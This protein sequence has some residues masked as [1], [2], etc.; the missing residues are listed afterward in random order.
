[1]GRVV[2]AT[3]SKAR[4]GLLKAAGVA[5]ETKPA[6]LEERA[7][8]RPLIDARTPPIGVA[9]GLAEAKALAVA[10]EARDAVVI[11]A[12]Q[13]L[14]C[15]GDIWHKP[16]S[17][18]EARRQLAALSGRTHCLHSAIA[19]AR[20]GKV[21]WRHVETARL[22]LRKLT[23]E[24]IDRYLVEVGERALASVGAYQLEG[25]GIRLF[26]KIE[27]DYFTILGLPLLPLLA[28]LRAEGEIE[29]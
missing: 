25:P 7:M 8:E 14:E 23:G 22:T 12:D 15:D 16:R 27:G 5:F 9:A 2:L 1:M 4:I 19:A 24:S 10:A 17:I 20:D 3:T 28:F 13:V 21:V 26:E 29:E 18:D 11:G 6:T